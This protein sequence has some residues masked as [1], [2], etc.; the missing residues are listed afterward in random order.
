MTT[1]FQGDP[2]V[3]TLSFHYTGAWIASLVRELRSCMLQ[4]AWP[5]KKKKGQTSSPVEDTEGEF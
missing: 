2:A 4:E 3:K 5:K 1:D